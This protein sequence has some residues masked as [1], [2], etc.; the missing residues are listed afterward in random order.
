MVKRSKR[1][2]QIIEALEVNKN[3]TLEQAVDILK[4][5]PSAKFDESVE[6]SLRIGVYPKKKFIIKKITTFQLLE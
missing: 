3:Y 2:K 6:I 5:S 1:Y 4:K